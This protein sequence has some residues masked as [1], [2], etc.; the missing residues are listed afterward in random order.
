MS[1]PWKNGRLEAAKLRHRIDIVEVNPAQDSTGGIDLSNNILV[2]TVWASV[3]PLTGSETLAAGSQMTVNTYQVLIRFLDDPST[4]LVAV[5]AANQIQWQ[6]RQFQITNVQNPDG[7][8]K[9]LC[10][11]CV[12]IDGSSQQG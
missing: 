9:M 7:R 10:L 6:G 11:T 3:E 8:K 5:T 4:G 12:E 1:T 2:A